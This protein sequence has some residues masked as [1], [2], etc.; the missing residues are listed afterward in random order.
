M[1]PRRR[2]RGRHGGAGANGGA[3]GANGQFAPGGRL[4]PGAQLDQ[5]A[6]SAVFDGSAE[7]ALA[8]RPAGDGAAVAQNGA[9]HAGGGSAGGPGGGAGA[10]LGPRRPPRVRAM[11]VAQEGEEVAEPRHT[12]TLAQMRRFIKSRSYVPVHELRRR[13]AIEGVEDEVSPVATDKGVIYVGLPPQEAQFLCDLIKAGEVGCE[14][15]LD[16]NSPA[17][18]G[19]FPMRPV[20]RQ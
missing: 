3:V 11:P 17:V 13:F 19:V 4:A 18:V 15:L 9:G 12:C 16:P 20:A 6:P 5:N 2:G 1:S 14:M 7:A 10:G 8:E